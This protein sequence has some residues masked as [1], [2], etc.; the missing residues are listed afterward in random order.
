MT[1]RLSRWLDGA[2]CD[3][4]AHTLT[5]TASSG[6][7]IVNCDQATINAGSGVTL[8]TPSTTCTGAADLP[9]GYEW[10]RCQRHCG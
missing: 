5:I 3:S 7:V 4:A 1:E 9:G 6:S 2:A 8:N 10:G